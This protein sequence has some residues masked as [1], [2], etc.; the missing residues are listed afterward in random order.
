MLAKVEF[1][2][3]SSG[4]RSREYLLA[5]GCPNIADTFASINLQR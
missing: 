2:A 4:Q 5:K 3:V 1:I